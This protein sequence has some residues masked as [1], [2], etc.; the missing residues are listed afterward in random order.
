MHCLCTSSALL[1]R[2][3]LEVTVWPHI[4]PCSYLLPHW[5]WGVFGLIHLKGHSSACSVF[6]P[7]SPHMEAGS[8][9]WPRNSPDNYSKVHCNLHTR[10][11]LSIIMILVWILIVDDTPL[12]QNVSDPHLSSKR[13]AG[14]PTW[15]LSSLFWLNEQWAETWPWCFQ[16]EAATNTDMRCQSSV[17]AWAGRGAWDPGARN[18][19]LFH[20]KH[21]LFLGGSVMDSVFC[22]VFLPGSVYH[23]QMFNKTH[24]VRKV[25]FLF[26]TE[27]PG[28]GRRES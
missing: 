11:V 14:W 1:H 22:M 3:S 19:R 15:V 26:Q 28:E 17:P 8:L 16:R 21:S 24:S 18:P 6:E 23:S 5:P 9:L 10:N 13:P 2:G 4:Y 20:I 7:P 27:H 12:G 25:D